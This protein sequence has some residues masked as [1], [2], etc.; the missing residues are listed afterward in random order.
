MSVW[1]NRFAAVSLRAA[2]VAALALAGCH[3]QCG[4]KCTPRGLW[5][6][7]TIHAT[8]ALLLVNT[9]E[10]YILRV[11]GRYVSPSCVGEGGMREYYLPAG[12]HSI[13]ASFRYQAPVGGGVIGTVAGKPLTLEH[14]FVAGREYVAV[15]RE[16]P[17]PR[18]EAKTLIEAISLT[19]F[20]AQD[21]TWSMD[22]VDLANVGPDAQ[23]QVRQAQL[24]CSLIKT[25]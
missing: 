16:H 7:P 8:R 25:L 6:S 5:E 24:Y 19:L 9:P 12:E 23:P 1:R 22:I 14:R 10:L 13:T 4:S 3:S 21:C 20:P 15:Y 18:P 11:D 2:L 17:R